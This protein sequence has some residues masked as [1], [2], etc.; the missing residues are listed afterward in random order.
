MS[1][2][3]GQ[4]YSIIIGENAIKPHKLILDPP[5][6]FNVANELCSIKTRP[7]TD[8]AQLSEAGLATD[9]EAAEA[10]ESVSDVKPR[11][12]RQRIS[13]I[14]RKRRQRNAVAIQQINA[15]ETTTIGQ[16]LTEASQSN[17][18]APDDMEGL[19]L[20]NHDPAQSWDDSDNSTVDDT[21]P[22]EIHG[23]SRLQ[24]QLRK[25]CRE[26]YGI[27]SRTLSQEPA[28]LDPMNIEVEISKWHTPKARSPP[29]IQTREKEQ[30][31]EKQITQ[32]LALR[33]IRP[34]QAPHYSQ[35]H[36]VPKPNNKWRF[37][38]DYR[39]LNSSTTPF[40][41]PMPNIA[42]TLQRIGN[43]RPKFFAKFDMTSG[44]FQCPLS[45][46]SKPLTAFTTFLGVYEWNRVPMGQMN[47][48]NH[49]QQQMATKVLAGYIYHICELYIDDCIVYGDTE[50]EF[51]AN[52]RKLFLRFR[53]FGIT[54][55]PDKCILGVDKI[56]YTG[57]VIDS[58]GLSFTEEKR[59]G[60][61]AFPKPSTMHQLKS[62]IGLVNYFRDHVRNMSIELQPLQRLVDSYTKRMKNKPVEWTAE[63]EQ[64]FEH[65]KQLVH[66]CQKLYF[67]DNESPIFLETD[68]SDYGIGAFQVKDDKND[69]SYLSLRPSQLYNSDG[70]Y[71]KKSVMQ[72]YMRSRR[73][74][75][76]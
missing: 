9:S 53:Q 27:F 16:F 42:Q 44:Y 65:I 22:S 1:K 60:V 49:F 18:N 51:L 40:G 6:R 45:E 59:A 64:Q 7:A 20:L 8:S 28:K 21:M 43:K 25:L 71:L 67:M 29:R 48:G 3:N 62:F 72:S 61:L 57:H 69:R 63:L 76:L 66:N 52:V 15:V 23:S 31:I 24:T 75:I 10:E 70:L 33:L 2:S 26:F 68:A 58:S 11:R 35:V 34:S 4:P 38:I 5:S 17:D 74:P 41:W 19:D 32:L 54:L 56:E 12:K 37:C 46:A 73:W 47:A 55:N 50:E 39:D 13:K 36:L 14:E 30:E